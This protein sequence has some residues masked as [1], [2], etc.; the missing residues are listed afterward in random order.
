MNIKQKKFQKQKLG[1]NKNLR[2]VGKRKKKNAIRNH[3]DPLE[4]Y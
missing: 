3:F 4:K 1:K 2:K